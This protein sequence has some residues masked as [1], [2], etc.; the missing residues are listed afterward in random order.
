MDNLCALSC[1]KHACCLPPS[2]RSVPVSGPPPA[3]LPGGGV[4]A[5]PVPV[6]ARAV[7]VALQPGDLGRQGGDLRQGSGDPSLPG[8][9]RGRLQPGQSVRRP[10]RF[11]RLRRQ[12]AGPRPA[13]QLPPG[14]A[15]VR[16]SPILSDRKGM[17]GTRPDAVP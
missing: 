15:G 11:L 6:R 8:R 14:P 2:L 9:D 17:G 10:E 7:Q 12:G 3:V 1:G 13:G 16:R 5:L 4:G